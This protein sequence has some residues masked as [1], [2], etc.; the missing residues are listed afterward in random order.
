[1][2]L[3]APADR[4]F[5]EKTAELVVTNPFH[6]DW[7]ARQRDLLGPQAAD[8]GDV[9]SWQPGWGLWGPRTIYPDLIRLGDRIETLADRIC[10]RLREGA[11]ADERE[12][13]L[14]Q[15]LALY[16][17]Y[18]DCGEDFDRHVDAFVRAA[19]ARHAGAA[20][21]GPDLKPLWR[22]FLADHDRL[23]AIP[24][25]A[26]PLP[27]TAEHLFA[28]F[29]TLRRAFYHV[30]FN[31]V[32]GSPAVARLRSAVW[33]SIITCDLRGWSLGLCGRM[34]DTP[35]LVTGPSGTGKELVAQAIG[36]SLYLP[37]DAKQGTFAAPFLEAFRPVNLSALP[38]TLI[39]SELF[40][41]VKGAFSF[42]VRDRVG[43][44]EEC[45]ANGAVFLDEIG[46][47]TGELQV[48]LLRVLQERSFQRVGENAT[49]P[50]EGKII[51]A[52]NRDLAREIEQSR[53]REDLY[54]RLCADRII[55]PSL[56]EQLAGRPD[57][58]PLLVGFVCRR[59]VGEEQ[60]ERF[61][62]EVVDWIERNLGRGYAWPG[63][64]R[65]L[66][67]CVRSYAIRKEYQPLRRADAVESACAALADDVAAGRRS[68]DEIE[69][70]LFTLVYERAGSWQE[71][72]RLLGRN[73]RTVKARV[74]GE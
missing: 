34:K 67:Q 74:T 60:A 43:R 15:A 33:Q 73:W 40:G 72:G 66:E 8:L 1:M 26:W 39:E 42:A 70:R 58:L 20:E 16:C 27:L 12:L 30:F 35:T 13:R 63:N 11:V 21:R 18:R 65:E 38:P 17:L 69:R 51:A 22:R 55:T 49:R 54:Y 36:R 25:R 61:C 62:A 59:V 28:C 48:K 19:G 4:A 7:M 53:F 24:G 44:L 56:R 31:I 71:A 45:P 37:F 68:Y 64:F 6:A 14:Y 3:F 52:T 2:P 10:R 47:L 46:E 23:L 32:G 41:H 50:F 9:Y 57:D 5:A 29:F